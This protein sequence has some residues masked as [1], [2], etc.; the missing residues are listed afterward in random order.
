MDYTE[1]IKSSCASHVLNFAAFRQTLNSRC[2]SRLVS[3]VSTD[4]RMKRAATG[5]KRKKATTARKLPSTRA[6]SKSLQAKTL[7]IAKVKRRPAAKRKTAATTKKS[8][9]RAVA[10]RPATVKTL[11][12]KPKVARKPAVKSVVKKTI[13]SSR[14]RK[15]AKPSIASPTSNPLP[16][17]SG[18]TRSQKL[19][20][21]TGARKATR[22]PALPIPA[23]LLEG[24]EPSFLTEG[25]AAEKF[26]LGPTAPPDHFDEGTA[27]L[28]ASYNTGRLFLTARDPHWLY[29]HWDFSHEEQFRHNARSVDRHLIVRIHNALQSEKPVS[30]IHIHPESKHW[31]AHVEQAGEQYVAELGY[32]SAG[33]RWKSLAISAPQRTPPDNISADSTITFA[34][35]PMEL[36]FETMLAMLKEG[37]VGDS[38]ENIP[39]ARAIENIRLLTRDVFPEAMHIANWTTEQAQSLSALLTAGRAGITLP[40][41]QDSDRSE[42]TPGDESTF[43]DSP[44]SYASSFFGGEGQADFWFNVNAE[45]IIYGATEPNASVSLAGKQIP[46]RADG[47]FNFR[48]AL[49]DGNYALP[50]VAVSADGTDGRGVELK[51][52]RST[53][54]HGHVQAHPQDPALNPP[55]SQ[56]V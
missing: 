5:S 45:L 54:T 41:S 42:T 28:P 44:S 4:I 9:K 46:L 43:G 55:P 8:I 20:K 21:K 33:H 17:V 26:A 31:F 39:L 50:V 14:R 32:Y 2:A 6:K 19:P 52:Q 11:S 3:L 23:F 35:I 47:S 24:D 7:A 48:F 56:N 40:S 18:Y 25:G 53:E 29:A 36:S 51:F 1:E 15:E 13:P 16:H 49:P 12:V 34:T 30:E 10:K 37:S 27:P 22:K 38:N